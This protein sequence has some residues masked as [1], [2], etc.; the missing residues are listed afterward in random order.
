MARLPKVALA[1]T[2]AVVGA[3]L[4][5]PPSRRQALRTARVAMDELMLRVD[6]PWTQDLVLLTSEGHHS[7][8]PRTTVLSGVNHEGELY[9]V[10]WSPDAEWLRNVRANPDV[11]VDD[12]VRVHRA[13]AQMVDGDLAAAVRRRWLDEHLPPPLRPVVARQLDREHPVVRLV[14]RQPG[15]PA[16]APATSSPGGG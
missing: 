3:A 16:T 15:P 2:G 9:V 6:T 11:V 10:P 1:V 4:A 12:R 5:Y 7:A 14:R 13:T 8:L